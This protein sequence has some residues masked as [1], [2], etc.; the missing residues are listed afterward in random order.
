MT[1]LPQSNRIPRLYSYSSWAVVCVGLFM[2][3]LF[4]PWFHYV[5]TMSGGAL[6]VRVLGGALGIVGAPAAMIIWFGMTFFCA[7]EDRSPVSVR[8]QWFIV[9]LVAGP[10]GSAIYFFRVYRRQ[11]RGGSLPLAQRVRAQVSG[12]SER[13]LEGA[14]RGITAFL[15]RAKHWQIFLFLLAGPAMLE[16]AAIGFPPNGSSPWRGSGSTGYLDLIAMK[17]AVLCLVAWLGSLASFLRSVQRAELRMKTRFFRFA[18]AYAAIYS[19]AFFPEFIPARSVPAL[20]TEL[21][22][23]LCVTCLFYVLYFA[24]KNFALAKTG[25]PASFDV[26]VV[27]FFLLWFFPIGVWFVQPKVNQL[28]RL[29]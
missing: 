17:L 20:V 15:L 29:A 23:L 22:N 12:S 4:T 10:F 24:A 2:I 8:I 6:L 7:R 19:I 5:E 9:F 1:Q 27:P 11:V 13:R 25:K 18:V 14:P 21:L 28:F 3:F 26:Y 16:L